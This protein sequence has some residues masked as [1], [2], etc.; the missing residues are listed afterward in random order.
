MKHEDLAI[1]S[2]RRAVSNLIPRMTT[3]ALVSYKDQIE[4]ENPGFD[5]AKFLYRLRRTEYEK[6]YGNQYAHPGFGSRLLARTIDIVPK[7]GPL[8]VFKLRV[9]D[10]A[11]Q[12]V[13]VKSINGTVDKFNSYL[14]SLK[15]QAPGTPSRGLDLAEIDLDTGKPA[16][17]GEYR[18]ADIAYADL[19][20]RLLSDPHQQMTADVRQ[21]FTDFYAARNEPAWY[22]SKPLQWQKL[23]AALAD[24]DRRSGSSTDSLESRRTASDGTNSAHAQALR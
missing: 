13:Y 6:E 21:S 12:D 3:V 9:P 5:R 10:A 7:I 14:S 23:S 11:Q 17:L 24:F 2:Y 4:Q 15:N 20:D 1:G 22:R 8:K 16:R 18:L 19:L